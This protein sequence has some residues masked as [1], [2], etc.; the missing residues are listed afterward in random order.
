MPATFELSV[1]AL[2]ILGRQMGVNLHQ[3]PLEIPSVAKSVE[4]QRA[5][6]DAVWR[7]LY[8]QGLARNGRLDPDVE[9]ALFALVRPEIA[10]SLILALQGGNSGTAARGGATPRLSVAAVQRGQVVRFQLGR[11]NE[12]VSGLL[13]IIPDSPPLPRFRP[14]SIPREDPKPAKSRDEDE[15]YGGSIMV[16]TIPTTPAAR[17]REALRR[18][19]SLPTV[20]AG[21]LQVTGRNKATETIGWTDT[22]DG[23]YLIHP[24]RQSDGVIWDVYRAVDNRE[25][26]NVIATAIST[27]TR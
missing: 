4:E 21:F 25:L 18:V 2:D 17:D 26:A 24:Q 5:I 19:R 11:P 27:V 10:A 20:R 14:L 1:A 13:S 16:H 23:R 15:S 22:R 12:L 8:Q 3:E 9:S 6:A 7:T